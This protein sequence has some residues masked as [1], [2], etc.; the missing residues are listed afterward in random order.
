MNQLHSIIS[1]RD[2]NLSAHRL[3]LLPVIRSSIEYVVRFGKVT[4]DRIT[5]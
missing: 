3:L 5:L 1:Y 2:I 4:R